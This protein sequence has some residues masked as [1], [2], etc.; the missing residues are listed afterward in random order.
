MPVTG[1]NPSLL[2]ITVGDDV[3][4][5][6]I[7]GNGYITSEGTLEPRNTEVRNAD[8]SWRY[9]P[10]QLIAEEGVQY[11]IREILYNEDYVGREFLTSTVTTALP[12]FVSDLLPDDWDA[13][14]ATADIDTRKSFVTVAPNPIAG[15]KWRVYRGPDPSGNLSQLADMTFSAG[16]WRWT[17][18][19]QNA[20]NAIVYHRIAASNA[21]GTNPEW[22]VILD[23]VKSFVASSVP[24]PPLWSWADAGA[25]SI[26][27]TVSIGESKGREITAMQYSVSGG[28]YT[29]AASLS[30]FT[31]TGLTPNSSIQV[32][33]RFVN[34]NGNSGDTQQTVTPAAV[35]PD[36]APT[37]TVRTV[38][39]LRELTIY[40]ENISG[41]L[42]ITLALSTLTLNGVNVKPNA[43]GTG[44][45]F[46]T[47]P[48][49]ASNSS[50]GYTVTAT[51]SV[52]SANVSALVAF[53]ADSAPVDPPDPS[54][55][56]TAVVFTATSPTDTQ[57]VMRV[58]VTGVPV[59]STSLWLRLITTGSTKDYL[60][61]NSPAVGVYNVPVSS[62]TGRRVYVAPFGRNSLGD[63]PIPTATNRPAEWVSSEPVV[64]CFINPTKLRPGDRAILSVD[65]RGWP[66]ADL[67]SFVLTLGGTVVVMDGKGPVRS[68]DI[69]MWAA[70][71]DL[72]LSATMTNDFATKSSS[73]VTVISPA[74]TWKTPVSIADRT[75]LDVALASA[76]GGEVFNLANGSYGDFTWSK[77]YT[78]PVKLVGASFGVVFGN[79][80]CAGASYGRL[81]ME[82]ISATS[83][84]ISGSAK[85]VR[86]IGCNLLSGSMNTAID[87]VIKDTM[88]NAVNRS[89]CFT[90]TNIKGCLISGNT[91]KDSY[92]DVV[93]IISTSE[94]CIFE[95]NDCS[96]TELYPNAITTAP[97][98]SRNVHPDCFQT[99]GAGGVGAL[100]RIAIRRNL[101]YGPERS[102]GMFMT[103]SMSVEGYRSMSIHDNCSSS[104]L[105]QR[106]NLDHMSIGTLVANNSVSGKFTVNESY[107]G[108]VSK[109]LGNTIAY[110]PNTAARA[111]DDYAYS[112][113]P[114]TIP[115]NVRAN[116]IP[117]PLLS[118]PDSYGATAYLKSLP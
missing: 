9:L 109:N 96:Y 50:V 100:N 45:W 6:L 14:E 115:L 28:A 103:D 3:V 93:R 20:E 39:S 81:Y 118:I 10:E 2:P 15:K 60:I 12:V 7:P 1:N 108:K 90:M 46:Y 16:V 99:Y 47:V 94:N 52:S 105:V 87:C 95:K 85:D 98:F 61:T 102:Q 111:G 67:D 63:G 74:I 33:V 29:T 116:F 65:G 34:A 21:D 25:G 64:T 51:N 80:K 110:G 104:N 56:T 68:Y 41:S 23:D 13:V 40:P 73:S 17:S 42:P 11:T 97:P 54:L 55:I 4:E 58:N 70:G 92:Y 83:I 76:S 107:G 30:S 77:G 26:L 106:F 84:S 88:F 75:A 71:Q 78:V 117:D 19:G 37:F 53:A 79:L 36:V 89:N 31:L 101:V 44:P 43:T 24:Q 72:V 86:L 5:K 8:N 35:A 22:V 59:N 66:E 114:Y 27:G 91:F 69:P 57:G 32:A 38:S 18:S 113:F 48:S 49:S 112:T 82:G 62:M